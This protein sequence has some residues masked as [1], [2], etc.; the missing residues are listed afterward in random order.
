[1]LR[2]GS[3]SCVAPSSP[4]LIDETDGTTLES[5]KGLV[6]NHLYMMTIDERGVKATAETVKLL[7]R[8]SY[9]IR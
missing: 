9:S 6:K 3:A 4:G 5:G 8:G 7:V 1:M 2:V